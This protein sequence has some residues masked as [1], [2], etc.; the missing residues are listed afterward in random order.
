[1]LN[2]IISNITNFSALNK[3]KLLIT[4]TNNYFYILNN[5]KL[6]VLN[7]NNYLHIRLLT[8]EFYVLNKIVSIDY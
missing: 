8:I 4:N 1:M 3:T 7:I 2:K 6:L 5:T